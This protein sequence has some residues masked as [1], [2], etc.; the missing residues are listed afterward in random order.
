VAGAPNRLSP[1]TSTGAPSPTCAAT[2]KARCVVPRSSVPAGAPA[3]DVLPG[4]SRTAHPTRPTFA[5]LDPRLARVGTRD[6]GPRAP[7]RS[8]R[9]PPPPP[10]PERRGMDGTTASDDPRSSTSSRGSFPARHPAWDVL[11]DRRV[12]PVLL[13]HRVDGS[14]RL[15][16]LERAPGALEDLRRPCDRWFVFQ[17]VLSWS[18]PLFLLEEGDARSFARFASCDQEIAPTRR[19]RWRCW[20]TSDGLD[21][22]PGSTGGSLEAGVLGQ[23]LYLEAEAAG[24][25]HR[26]RL[27][28]R[29]RRPRDA[30]ARG[31]PL[32]RP[33]P[34]HRGRASRTAGSPP[35]ATATTCGGAGAPARAR[36]HVRNRRLTGRLRKDGASL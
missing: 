31:R 3:N 1:P 7:A 34:L 6:D 14:A 36:V 17:A 24:A 12:H 9:R 5:Q 30:R 33:L 25:R 26:H 18:V 21:R 29:R 22:S 11:P 13:V 35:A 15:Y 10:A 8:F 16:L 23:A 32:P 4:L 27:L 28:L 2:G 19:S 20:P